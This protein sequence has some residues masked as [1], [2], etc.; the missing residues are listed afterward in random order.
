MLHH[1]SS[2]LPPTL[3]PFFLNVHGLSN[4]QQTPFALKSSPKHTFLATPLAFPNERSIFNS[5]LSFIMACMSR[6]HYSKS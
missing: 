2:S 1:Q 3:L 4:L 5:P 6:F